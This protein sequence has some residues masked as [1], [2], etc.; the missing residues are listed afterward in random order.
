MRDHAEP[1]LG[2]AEFHEQVAPSGRVHDDPRKACEQASPDLA[3]GSR[4]ARE[5]VVR[6]ED[7]R[8]SQ[9]EEPVVEL[10]RSEPLDVHDVG[11]EARQSSQ[12]KG[13]LDRL[14]RQSPRRAT[15][16]MRAQRVEELL[17]AV[18][19]RFGHVAEA[20][21]RRDEPDLGSGV[22]ER[23]RERMVVLRREGRRIGKQDPHRGL[24]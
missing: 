22:G 6:R 7:S 17:P 16:E 5:Q 24:D 3:A 20:E 13:M 9:P 19:D 18:V 8:C 21:R 2:D 10:W 14:Q 15:E 4:P 12:A 11:R 23:G 1:R